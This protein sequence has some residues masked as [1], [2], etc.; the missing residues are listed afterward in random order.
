MATLLICVSLTPCVHGGEF[1]A[2]YVVIGGGETLTS[3]VAVK[4]TLRRQEVLDPK[5]V[6]MA[7]MVFAPTK[8]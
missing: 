3:S 1:T 2:D 6:V 5:G 4:G 7:I 8:A